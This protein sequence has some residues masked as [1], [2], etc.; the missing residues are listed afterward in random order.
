MTGPSMTRRRLIALASAI[1]GTGVLPAFGQ[2]KPSCKLDLESG[3]W[4]MRQFLYADR[5]QPAG[6]I[7]PLKSTVIEMSGRSQQHS[8]RTA[9]S[10]SASPMVVL[11][12]GEAG[13][14][15]VDIDDKRL[16]NAIGYKINAATPSTYLTLRGG[17]ALPRAQVGL[18]V[19]VDG[20]VLA[21][22]REFS[23][24]RIDL[25]PLKSGRIL[26]FSVVDRH[27]AARGHPSIPLFHID[28]DLANFR[29]LLSRRGETA[30][31]LQMRRRDAYC[32]PKPAPGKT[33]EN[34]PYDGGGYGG[35]CFLTTACCEVVGLPD[36]CFELRALRRCRDD[37]LE[38]VPGSDREVNRYYALAPKLLERLAQ[39]P[40]AG[41]TL[42]FAYAFYILPCAILA[43][44]GGRKIVRAHYHALVAY[45]I[46]AARTRP[47]SNGVIENEPA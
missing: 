4:R 8:W 44:A 26:R 46:R 19:S 23:G 15:F 31:V 3:D 45:L 9:S 30:M 33:V 22:S 6:G 28:S 11:F 7:V 20:R 24:L 47:Q 12:D 40:D 17:V 35:G 39:H 16:E 27:G 18:Q 38:S 32:E 14:V 37:A 2:S 10:K 42:L 36:D 1:A 5:V 34:A 43:H 21:E 25:E 41:R 13:S 29:S